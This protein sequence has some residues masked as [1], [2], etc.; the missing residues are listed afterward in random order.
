[1]RHIITLTL[2][3]LVAAPAAAEGFEPVSDKSR[4]VDLV[5]GRNLTHLGVSLTVDP[6]GTIRGRAFGRAVTGNWT[7]EAGYFCR[8]MDWGSTRFDR[9]CQAVGLKGS[10]MRFQSDRGQ[11]EHADLTLR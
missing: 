3:T 1:M 4:F 9:N 6:D 8:T 11:G 10:V 5:R 7:W 2:S